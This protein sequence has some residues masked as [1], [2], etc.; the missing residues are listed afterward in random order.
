AP[1]PRDYVAEMDTEERLAHL[2]TEMAKAAENLEFE[3]A[4]K[5]RDEI[6]GMR[7]P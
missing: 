1:E 5:I 7:T 4:A 2:E 3:R 6:A